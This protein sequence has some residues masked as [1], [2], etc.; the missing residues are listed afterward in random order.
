[1]A[2]NFP[3]NPTVGQKYQV[4][5]SAEYEFNGSFWT[6]VQSSP[7]EILSADVSNFTNST[8]QASQLWVQANSY[9]AGAI[10]HRNN[11]LYRA[12]NA[13]PANTAFLIGTT[14]ATWTAVSA[15]DWIQTTTTIGA[16][17]TAP[18]KGVVVTDFIRYRQIAPNEYEVDMLY[19]QSS[20]GSAGNGDYLFTLPGNLAFN[21][22]F[23]PFFTGVGGI[24]RDP[25]RTK[26]VIRG[27][28]GVTANTFN[29]AGLIAVVYDATRFKLLNSYSIDNNASVNTVVKSD[30]SQMGNANV[31]YSMR[32]TFTAG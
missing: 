9:V 13:I 30:Y 32:F 7:L 25:V 10:V 2:L 3:I 17:T 15:G 21:S 28:H 6:V 23:H 14:G 5:N 19:H 20:G 29:S 16:T 8:A 27:S 22:T 24:G 11:I 1:M 31:Q 26:C 12:N 4:D 18:T